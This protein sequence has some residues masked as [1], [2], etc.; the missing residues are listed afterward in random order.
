MTSTFVT[1][2]FA[3][4]LNATSETGDYPEEIRRGILTPLAKPPKKDERVNVRPIILLSVLHKTITIAL[5]DQC[6]EGMKNYIPLSQA[7]YEKSRSST[8][9]LFTIKILAE[10]SITYENYEIFLLLL[11]MSNRKPF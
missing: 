10:K 4:L 8:E 1:F 5:I 6:L 11:D 7:A 2:Q 3:S 9:Q